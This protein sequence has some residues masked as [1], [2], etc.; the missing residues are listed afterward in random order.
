MNL[1]SHKW[2]GNAIA[3]PNA[4]HYTNFD[5][6]IV[7]TKESRL[8]QNRISFQGPWAA[9]PPGVTAARLPPRTMPEPEYLVRST[10]KQ[11]TH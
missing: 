8:D 4:T 11:L 10:A 6:Y 7:K 5:K 3:I 9:P 1:T 2:V